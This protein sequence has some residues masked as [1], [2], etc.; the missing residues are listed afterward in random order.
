MI[1]LGPRRTKA[2]IP[3]SIKPAIESGLDIAPNPKLSPRFGESTRS[4]VFHLSMWAPSPW[5]AVAGRSRAGDWTARWVAALVA[6]ST[7]SLL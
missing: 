2:D 3:W 6:S 1:Q 5:T 4:R 7:P